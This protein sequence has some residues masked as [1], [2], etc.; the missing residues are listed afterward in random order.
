MLWMLYSFFWVFPRRLNFMN[1]RFENQ[2]QN[3]GNYL[4]ERVL[5]K[6]WFFPN[7]GPLTCYNNTHKPLYKY[8]TEKCINFSVSANTWTR[9][10]PKRKQIFCWWFGIKYI[11]GLEAQIFYNYVSLFHS[12]VPQLLC[13]TQ[14]NTRTKYWYVFTVNLM[15]MYVVDIKCF[16]Q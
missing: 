9:H 12:C 7:H 11:D 8:S 3:T 16:V 13:D 5:H 4:K 15:E 14:I 1:R 10:V 6:T 2:V